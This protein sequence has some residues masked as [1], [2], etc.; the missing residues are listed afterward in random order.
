MSHTDFLESLGVIDLISE[1]H[2]QLRHETM[3]RIKK[4]FEEK[5]SVTDIYLISLIQHHS[6]SLS[7]AARYMKVS[8]QA[9]HK[10][11]NHLIDLGLVTH[12]ISEEN[13]KKKLITLT[14]TGTQLSMQI[15]MI[16]NELEVEL[17]NELGSKYYH[18]IKALLKADWQLEKNGPGF[19]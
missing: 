12:S 9:V 10:Q 18:K 17:E 3:T 7:E 19:Q 14:K 8:R 16:K 1:K 6:I 5:F 11:V 15:N 13:R 2:K 4:H